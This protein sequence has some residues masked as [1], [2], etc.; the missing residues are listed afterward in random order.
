MAKSV[1]RCCQSRRVEESAREMEAAMTTAAR[2]PV[3]GCARGRGRAEHQRDRECT[4]EP[5][6]LRLGAVLFGDCLCVTR[7]C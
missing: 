3:A 4:H 6:Q 7:L 1:R 5:G 2:V